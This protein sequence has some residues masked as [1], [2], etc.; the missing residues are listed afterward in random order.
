MSEPFRVSV[1]VPVFN[2]ES[3]LRETVR[4]ALDQ[5]QVGEILLVEDGSSDG[6]FALCRTLEAES[7][8]RVRVLFHDGH[9]NRG[10]GESRNLGIREARCP[11]LAFLDADDRYNPGA[12]DFDERAFADPKVGFVRHALANGFDPDDPDQ[13]WFV[14]YTGRKNALAKYH[15]FVP[16]GVTPATYFRNL[17]PM[18][19]LSSGIA[20]ILTIRTS[21]ARSLGGLP[22]RDWA[23]DTTFHAKLAAAARAA[24]AP[25]EPAMAVRRIHSANLSKTK[26]GI[27]QYRIDRTG[28]A[29]L[30][31][32]AFLKG[33]RP[34]AADRA[35]LHRGWLRFGRRYSAFSSAA[36]LRLRPS[37]LFFPGVAVQYLR[38]YGKM[39]CELEAARLRGRCR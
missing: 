11:F 37:D 26:T 24:I 39:L 29:M 5:P 1:I 19:D 34:S 21:V 7:D 38:F 3:F 4:S 36:L 15:S 20:D 22:P 25:N 10:P 31:V 2:A 17:Y 16:D 23:E 27:P 30:D 12:F 28:E 13:A 18:G 6:S 14:G 8:G 35:A 33:R 9:A 32:G